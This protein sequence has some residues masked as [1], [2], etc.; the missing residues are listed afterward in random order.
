MRTQ[1]QRLAIFTVLSLSSYQVFAACEDEVHFNL[2]RRVSVEK[3]DDVQDKD[4]V[5]IMPIGQVA[6]DYEVKNRPQDGD[7]IVRRRHTPKDADDQNGEPALIFQWGARPGNSAFLVEIHSQTFVIWVRTYL[8]QPEIVISS[9]ET[10][11]QAVYN[12]SLGIG[13]SL[14][15]AGWT[16][17]AGEKDTLFLQTEQNVYV[18]TVDQLGR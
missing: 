4:R 2:A 14:K 15:G 9:V 7:V 8:N 16:V 17:T 3:P 11:L 1:I 6:G 5:R 18:I 10:P 12:L 13:E